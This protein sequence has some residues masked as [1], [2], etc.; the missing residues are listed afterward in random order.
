MVAAFSQTQAVNYMAM[1]PKIWQSMSELEPGNDTLILQ[2]TVLF[3][4]LSISNDSVIFEHDRL[5]KQRNE[6]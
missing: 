3:A 5:V 1:R 4:V 6:A 2:L